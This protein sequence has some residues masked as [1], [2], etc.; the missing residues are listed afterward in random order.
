MK[1][2]TRKILVLAMDIGSS[3]TRSA[4]FDEKARLI[5]GTDA[6]REYSVR[7]S[8]DGG[9]E[10]SPAR[11]LRAAGA[12]LRETLHGHCS[13]KLRNVP[14][15]AVGGS[16]FW[17]SLLGLDRN[18]RSLT[19]IF[20]WAD[21]RSTSDAARL[22]EQFIERNIQAE[23]GCML[24]SSF[25]PAKLRWLRRTDR[26]LFRKVC[27]WVSPADWIFAEL[28]GTATSSPSMASGTGLYDLRTKSWHA[29]LRQACEIDIES[30]LQISG[31]P[32]RGI[33]PPGLR[34]AQ[35]FTAI[36]DGAAGNLGCGADGAGRVAINLGTSAAVRTIEGTPG[37]RRA[38]PAGLFRY[39]VDSE[40][41]VMGGAISNAGNLRRW[42]TRELRIAGAEEKA[43][44]RQAAADDT[45]NVLPFWVTERAPTWPENLRGTIAGLTQST[46]AA[47][48][49]RATTSATL[50]RLAEILSSIESSNGR[51][52]EIIVSGGATRSAALM[53]L[54]ADALGRDLL[55][56]ATES[57]LRGAARF[58]LEK[59]GYEPPSG[60]KAKIVRHDRRLAQKHRA[61]R[62]RQV[63]LESM[64]S[65][66]A[67]IAG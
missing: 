23:T 6:R 12:C 65:G 30:L 57:S 25:W 60:P 17:H 33:S 43:L 52:K 29:G 19:P 36:G 54:L 26:Q 18:G 51:A 50:Y 47:E 42:C 63:A 64:L 44:D 14:I 45:L 24:R 20:T 4:L 61:R 3:S 66:K 53:A 15:A 22:R 32:L 67:E 10:L 37:D 40:R 38:V 35:V 41:T 13:S 46:D 49:F 34:D 21:S 31:T 27:R 59:L 55:V 16:A 28:F 56:S 1:R 39:V 5:S 11:L 48:I 7:Y 58:A 62:V 8:K 9:A 2:G